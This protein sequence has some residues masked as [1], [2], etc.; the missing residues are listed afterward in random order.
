MIASPL[1]APKSVISSDLTLDQ[2]ADNINTLVKQGNTH[3]HQIGVFY[4]H[5]V[6]KRLAE[7]GGYKNARDF[8]VK[9]VKALSQA[10]LSAYGTVARNFPE[11]V[12]T[13]YG[14][15][16][17]RA[18]LTYAEVTGTTVPADPG[19]LLIDVPQ[20]DGTLLKV[21]FA[22]CTV[23]DVERATRAK[24]TPPRPNV[25]TPDA[26]RLLLIEDSVRRHFTG[27]ANVSLSSRNEGGKTLLN[28]QNVPMVELERFL[29][30]V[31]EGMEA[32]PTIA[33]N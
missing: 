22:D 18:L 17:L 30:A 15:F 21:R 10:T 19:P 29:A 28:M 16:N 11:S 5:V 9:R 3:Q 32:A 1:T 27:I 31:R 23:D 13:Q 2:I 4:N 25:P 20:E 33:A 12:A 6:D 14:M 7:M 26:A 8:F 24:R